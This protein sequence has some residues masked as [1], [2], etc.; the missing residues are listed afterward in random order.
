MD[1]SV[2]IDRIIS[3][4]IVEN[5]LNRLT[6]VESVLDVAQYQESIHSLFDSEQALEN[7]ARSITDA[8]SGIIN[9]D[10]EV[11]VIHVEIMKAINKAM[12]IGFLSE[13]YVRDQVMDAKT[14]HDNTKLSRDYEKLD[15][16]VNRR[17]TKKDLKQLAKDAASK[18][19]EW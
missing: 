6:D 13:R 11:G 3:A 18:Q 2:S 9:Q 12:L 19:E 5:L 1:G 8:A 17:L 7:A 4:S 16:F 14:N 15:D 10:T